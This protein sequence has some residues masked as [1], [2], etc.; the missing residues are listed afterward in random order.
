MQEKPFV[1]NHC[2][3]HEACKINKKIF[4]KRTF[5]IQYF[6]KK[7]KDLHQN[8]QGKRQKDKNKYCFFF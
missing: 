1:F 2:E 3:Q 7:Y 4:N 8:F 6:S 5:L